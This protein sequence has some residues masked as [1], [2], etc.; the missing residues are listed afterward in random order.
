MIA[1]YSQFPYSTLGYSILPPQALPDKKK[2]EDWKKACMDAMESIGIQQV[3]YKAAR[4]EDAYRLLDGTYSYA[5]VSNSSA[6]LS[7]ADYYANQAGTEFEIEHYGFLEPVVNTL[8]GEYM[9]KPDGLM[10][11]AED[12]Y[13]FND[14]TRVKTERLMQAVQADLQLQLNSKLIRMGVDPFKNQFESEEEKQAYIQQLEQFKQENTPAHIEQF[15][16]T[17]WKPNYIKWVEKTLEEDKIR[18][19][20]EDITRDN[21]KDYFVT[22]ETFRHWRVG[23]DFFE[24]ERW[25]PLNTFHSLTDQ[26]RHVHK[27]DYVG[28]IHNFSP[29]DVIRNFGHLLTEKQIRQITRS[30]DR[31]MKDYATERSYDIIDVVRQGGGTLRGVPHP[32]HIGYENIGAAQRATGVDFG[33]RGYFPNF[34]Q[35]LGIPLDDGS[36]V[37]ED[38]IT[39]T[40]AYWVS[41]KR[42]GLL[43]IED[44]EGDLETIR[45]TDEILREYIREK[46]IKQLR[47]VTIDQHE[48][49]PKANTIV[50][51]YIPE[52][53]KGIKIR[54]ENTDL[55][56]S[57]YVD[58]KPLDYQ[59]RG[60][61]EYYDVY[62][63]VTGIVERGSLISRVESYQIDYTIT[64]NS[65]KDY[66]TKEMGMIFLFD[67]AYLPSE[68][69]D[70]GGEE[71]L[72][73]ITEVAKRLGMMPVNSKEARTG[74]NQLQA[75]NMDMTQAMLQ[76]LQLATAYKIQAFQAL[77][78][79]P[80]RMLLPVEQKTATGVE[81]SQDASFSQTEMWFDKFT[82]FEIASHEMHINIAQQM[83]KSGRDVTVNYTDSDG[84]KQ[85]LSL[86]DDKLPLRRFRIYPNIN[87]KRRSELE[88]MKRVFMEDNTIEKTMED[89]ATIV[90]SDSMSTIRELAKIRKKEAEL[91]RQQAELAR[92]KQIEMQA[93]AEERKL[94]IE[95][96][97]KMEQERLKGE[98]DIQRQAILALGF[99]ENKD[100]NENQ[101][102]DVIEAV[103]LML[104]ESNLEQRAK[105]VQMQK[106]SDDLK[107]QRDYALK[108]Q[109]LNLK[110][111]EIE[112]KKLDS[113]T[114]LQIARENKYKHEMKK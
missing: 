61:S 100:R 50:W 81:V 1:D 5:E 98:L 59:I 56:E 109:E 42:I 57:I 108:Q 3:N 90:S 8:I 23:Y 58:I 71:A 64:M 36:Y 33:Y 25:S 48:A 55:P 110:K 24:P 15:M 114:K 16:K 29:N 88:L 91:Q 113:Q 102:A 62:L 86:S 87:S 73:K 94:A 38:L 78:L 32:H 72:E 89:M 65:A 41:Q 47:T 9:K 18:Y 10:I 19:N 27:G 35:N 105:E 20:L 93:A 75:V 54:N 6:F 79:S 95:H 43:T 76:K 112:A 37:R 84:V 39:V 17:S 31:N 44:E 2:N 28:R 101:V 106:Q 21:L 53:W 13:S 11:H 85:M 46:G 22:G 7:E 97:Y 66:M 77:G 30:D 60:E 70:F 12:P 4:Y 92:Q 52:V 69:V 104:E 82:T 111:Q 51:S 83:K 74:F 67:L 45:V 96:Q 26:E 63:P 103:K 14:Y 68:V 99:D 40:E 107:S 34:N 49:Q 80:E